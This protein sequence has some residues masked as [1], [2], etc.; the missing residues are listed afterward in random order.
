[1]KLQQKVLEN[2]YIQ[3]EKALL[4]KKKDMD[5][6]FSPIFQLVFEDTLSIIRLRQNFID[7]LLA[8]LT[9]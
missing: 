7:K 6:D 8:L 4:E 5:G 2:E 9:S 1:M 3:T